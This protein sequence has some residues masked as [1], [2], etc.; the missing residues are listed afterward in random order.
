MDAPKPKGFG[1][2]DKLM[3][4]L[5]NVCVCGGMNPWK[6]GIEPEPV[7]C[8]WCGKRLDAGKTKE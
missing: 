8:G 6:V 4:G 1:E 3:K 7:K 5:I 2:F